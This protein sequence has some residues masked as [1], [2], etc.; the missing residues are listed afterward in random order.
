MQQ[1][2][3]YR[4]YCAATAQCCSDFRLLCRSG[5]VLSGRGAMGCADDEIRCGK[6]FGMVCALGGTDGSEAPMAR[7]T[8]FG[9][10]VV[11]R[12]AEGQRGVDEGS[13]DDERSIYL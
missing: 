10:D 1:V 7:P 9:V 4:G 8:A 6:D 3:S 5:G 11:A 2:Q 13:C 12:T